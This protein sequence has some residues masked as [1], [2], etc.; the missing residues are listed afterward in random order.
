MV[1][2]FVFFSCAINETF[3]KWEL[4]DESMFEGQT[5]I[6]GVVR[7][8]F[9][10]SCNS[11]SGE[12]ILYGPDGEKEQID[13]LMNNLFASTLI[14]GKHRVE[15]IRYRC[16]YSTVRG[17][18]INYLNWFFDTENRYA[19]DL[20]LSSSG[21]TVTKTYII[22]GEASLVVP[23][24]GFCKF[25]IV[26]GTTGQWSGDSEVLRKGEIALDMNKIPS[27]E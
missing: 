1:L 10:G 23:E 2:T 25:A 4:K 24:D 26:P 17:T 16:N 13:F 12:I 14:P 5:G 15:E 11:E 7:T 19:K 21:N 6:V 27:C 9:S 20:L 8:N 3:S 22:H 18:T